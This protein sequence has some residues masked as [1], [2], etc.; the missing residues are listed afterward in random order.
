MLRELAN[1][2]NRDDEDESPNS[3]NRSDF[4]G[5]D[6]SRQENHDDSRD[7]SG[8]EDES[9]DDELRAALRADGVLDE[10]MNDEKLCVNDPLPQPRCVDDPWRNNDDCYGST[11]VC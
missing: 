9:R 11:N 1:D 5:G 10:K 8:G 3:E 6:D 7:D 2:E 4:H